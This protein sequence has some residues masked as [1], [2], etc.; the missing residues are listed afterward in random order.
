[1]QR[2]A[3]SSLAC[4]RPSALLSIGPGVNHDPAGRNKLTDTWAEADRYE[5]YVGRWSRLVA[6]NFLEWLGVPPGAAWIDVGCGTGA[7]SHSIL[8]HRSPRM[9]VG[10]DR[11]FAYAAAARARSPANWETLTV[12]D[13]QSLPIGTAHFDVA[14]SGLVLNFVPDPARMIA[15]MSRVL[16]PKGR[17]AVY[18]WDYT[19]RMEL[20]RYFW[21]AAVQLDP[22]AA[23]LDEGKRFPICN[24]DRLREL[25]E[26]QGLAAVQFRPIDVP[27]V[28]RDFDD[29][30][31]PFLGG[32]GPAPGYAVSLSDQRRTQLRDLISRQL[33]WRA[34]GSIAL[35]ARAWAICGYKT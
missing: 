35:T 12:A 5:P 14:V 15:E 13:A 21:D 3:E 26:S 24:P 8:A 6:R 29:Y 4:A 17:L 18:V 9:L 31:A 33:P 23:E 30:W 25:L 10:I 1:M 7:L 28:F 34:D 16:R 22:A 11:S 20:M 19:D 2:P 27:T 32:Q